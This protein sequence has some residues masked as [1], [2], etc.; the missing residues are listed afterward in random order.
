MRFRLGEPV[1]T[2]IHRGE[3]VLGPGELVLYLGVVE[4]FSS[5]AFLPCQGLPQPSLGIFGASRQRRQPLGRQSTSKVCGT[6]P[7]RTSS[8]S[9]SINATARSRLI[10]AGDPSEVLLNHACPHIGPGHV[11]ADVRVLGFRLFQN[12]LVEPQRA[13]S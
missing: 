2:L 12:A 6:Y 5:D 4:A 8:G 3:V 11:Q 13:S 10:L 1:G 7:S 9:P